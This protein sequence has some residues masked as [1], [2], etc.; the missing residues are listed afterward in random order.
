MA[1]TKQLALNL[2][3][4]AQAP[5]PLDEA[6]AHRELRALADLPLRPVAPVRDVVLA[7]T[8]SEPYTPW[9]SGS[10]TSEAAAASLSEA[11]VNEQERAVL[12]YLRRCGA[13]GA[14]DMQ[15]AAAHPREMASSLRRARVGLVAKGCAMDSGRRLKNPDSGKR[16]VV[17]IAAEHA[18]NGEAA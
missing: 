3:G 15:V 16:V 9:V 14:T 8:R 4:Y 12:A 5:L 6:T 18:Q 1:E 17:W 7:V 10:D 11:R 13:D 2:S